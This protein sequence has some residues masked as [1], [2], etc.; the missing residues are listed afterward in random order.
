MRVH[1]HFLSKKNARKIIKIIENEYPLLFQEYVIGNRDVE[2]A[3]ININDSEY[4]IYVVKRKPLIIELNS[5]LIPLMTIVLELYNKYGFS[6]LASGFKYVLTDQGAMKPILRGADVMAPGII[7]NNEFLRGDIVIVFA[8]TGP[9]NV[10]IAVGE[11]LKDSKDLDY[12]RRG[13]IIKNLHRIGDK[14]WNISIRM[15]R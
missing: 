15:A 14:I 5:K 4:I 2:I 10:P 8:N 3:K 1:R 9:S 6:K 13:K 12:S 7:D 11:A